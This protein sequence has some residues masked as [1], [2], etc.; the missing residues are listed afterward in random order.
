MIKRGSKILVVEAYITDD[1]YKNGDI[2]TV[3]DP[4]DL[5]GM[6]FVFLR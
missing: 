2:L 1:L 5:L 3:T 4:N 6:G